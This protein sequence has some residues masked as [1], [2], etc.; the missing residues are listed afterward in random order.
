[1][2]RASK[3]F[4]VEDR[5]AVAEA[6]AEAEAKTS[7]EIVP[8]VATSS[9]RYDRAEDLFGMLVAVAAL[10]ASWLLFQDVRPVE[11][12]WATGQTL[13]LGLGAV[14]GVVIAGYFLGIAAASWLPFLRLPLITKREMREEVEEGAAAAF[15]KF[16]LRGTAGGTGILIYVSLYEHMV[17]VLPDEAI[18]DRV[19]HETWEEVCDLAVEGIRSGR[20]TDGLSRAVLR[21][22]EILAEHFPVGPDDVDELHNALHLLD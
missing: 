9:G 1:M 11:G 5:K 21:C 2:K 4:G 6:V 17:R 12:D 3:L 10:A 19:D 15:Q 8:V 18:E 7:G 14:L 20:P 13:V 22:G 16:R